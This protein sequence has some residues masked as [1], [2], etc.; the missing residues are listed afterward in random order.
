[1]CGSYLWCTFSQCLTSFGECT[2]FIDFYPP[3]TRG[4]GGRVL[5]KKAAGWRLPVDTF[6]NFLGDSG[7]LCLARSEVI[8]ILSLANPIS[9]DSIAN[10]VVNATSSA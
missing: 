1:M 6:H 10:M 9:K 2:E 8:V 3:T 5:L 4:S 7:F